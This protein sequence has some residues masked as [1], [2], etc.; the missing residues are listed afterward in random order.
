MMKDISK[1][2][3]FNAEAKHQ[4]ARVHLPVAPKCNIQCNY[5][6]RKY[7]CSNESRPGVTSTV[8]SPMQSVHYLK[9]LTSTIPN[10]SVIGIAGPGDPFANPEETL[11]TMKMV[12]QAFPDK[13]F[14][15][16]TNGLDLAP[17][18][19][20]LAEI[21]VSHVTIT[22]NSLRPETLANMYR[23]VRFNR[24]VYRGEA[25]GKVLLEQQLGNII[26]L[27]E[28]G[29][30][31]KIN[32]V[33]CPG[34]NDDEVEEVAQKVASLGAD[35]MNCIPLYPTENT[36]FALLPEPSKP[37]MKGI[38]A[39]ISKHIQPMAHCARCRAD[40]AGLLGHDNTVAMDMIGQFS[41]MTVNRSEGRTRVAVAS[42]EGL[43]VNLHLGE[44]RKVYV[45]EKSLNGYHFVEIR[46]TPP[47]GR[48][49]ARWEELAA[50]TLGDC[51]AILVAGI[52][53]TPMKVMQQNGIRVI[54]MS[55]LIDAG[56]DAVYLNLPVKT[57]CRSDY[58]KC[59]ESCRDAGNGCG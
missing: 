31:V 59:G 49:M 13:I 18:I 39:A 5:C 19:D 11:S 8:L 21:G 50:K 32:T 47:E 30:T 26:K 40:A 29:I 2:P 55:G 53:E 54:Q 17:Y 6:N 48:G 23:W 28:K 12:K 34:I 4:Y 14:C 20:E 7:D 16:S 37:M 42:N 51:Q 33:V 45:F 10:I 15:L 25:A 56:L 24:R 27:K 38:K 9:A 22:I 41:T 57:L 43:L 46:N 3:C 1:H 52:G 36:E 44:A 35:T 58:T